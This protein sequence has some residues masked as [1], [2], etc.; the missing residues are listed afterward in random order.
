MD[1]EKALEITERVLQVRPHY[2]LCG[3]AA[4]ILQ[5]AILPRSIN[6]LDFICLKENFNSEGLSEYGGYAPS[7]FDGYTTY[8]VSFDAKVKTGIEYYNV[9]VHDDLTSIKTKK[10]E[11][12]LVQ[13]AEDII[14]WKKKWRREKDLKDLGSSI[15]F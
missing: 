7:E 2:V 13:E 1:L 4:L 9:F 12:V 15:S 5:G 14:Y 6:D 11:G 3:S 10:V 8:K